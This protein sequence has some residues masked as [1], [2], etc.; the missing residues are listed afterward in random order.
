[1]NIRMILEGHTIT[2]SQGDDWKI[3]TPYGYID[4]HHDK[5]NDVNEIW[6]VESKKRGHGTELVNLMMK[7]HPSN[8]IAWG[9]TTESGKGLR[10]KW[11]RLHPGI[12][13]LNGAFEGQFDPSG[14]NY[15]EDEDLDDD[16]DDD[17]EDE[18]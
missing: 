13:Q 5:D 18:L 1:M 7:H 6:W 15:G 8:A 17:L 12:D 16:L 9:I 4:Y 2:N 3:T 11:H 10:D 14:N